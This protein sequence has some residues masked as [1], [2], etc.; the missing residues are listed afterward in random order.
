ME[1]LTRKDIEGAPYQKL[2]ALAPRLG[3]KYQYQGKEELQTI[4]LE[5]VSQM[6]NSSSDKESKEKVEKSK[7]RTSKS[8]K[9]EPQKTKSE[10]SETRASK[11]GKS[12]PRQY[13]KKVLNILDDDSLSKSDKMRKLYDENVTSPGEISKLVSAHYSFVYTVLSKYKN[14]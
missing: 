14:K 8:E 11:S 5:K 7:T 1:K 2:V 6:D 4:L 12:E 10:K 9:S 13:D 3:I